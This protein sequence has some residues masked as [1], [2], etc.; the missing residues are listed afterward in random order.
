MREH[1]LEPEPKQALTSAVW[2]PEAVLDSAGTLLRGLEQW[3]DALVCDFETT[4]LA[5]YRVLA[6]L[7]R[8][9]HWPVLTNWARPAGWPPPFPTS[10]TIGIR[11]GAGR[12][13]WCFGV[14]STRTSVTSMS[15]LRWSYGGD[16]TK[17]PGSWEKASPGGTW[18]S[19]GMGDIRGS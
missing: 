11:W 17:A 12:W 10:T 15:V 18:V 14:W 5:V 19:Y 6:N 1:G 8:S 7:G 9:E 13:R 2:P 16:D 3:P 4:A